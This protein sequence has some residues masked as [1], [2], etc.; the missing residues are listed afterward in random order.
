MTALINEAE[1]PL[2]ALM[3]NAGVASRAIVLGDHRLPIQLRNAQAEPCLNCSPL[4]HVITGG[5]EESRALGA[6]GAL[7]RPPLRLLGGLLKLGRLDQVA[8]INGQGYA[9]DLPPSLSEAEITA[10]TEALAAA[11]PDRA[12]VLRSL[13]RPEE[14]ERWR[15]AG[16]RSIVS[17]YIWTF[18]PAA[19]RALASPLLK[20]DGKLLA[21]SEYRLGGPES[22]TDEELPR[23]LTLY[24]QLY[25]KKYSR[26]NPRWTLDFFRRARD[27]AGPDL[28]VLRSAEG[29]IDGLVG[30]VERDGV[31]TAPIYGYDTG[32]PRELGLYRMLSRVAVDEARRRGCLLHQSAGAAR[33]K[34][35]RRA[36]GGLEWMAVYDRHLPRYRR[37]AWGLLAGLANGL[38]AP[39]LRRLEGGA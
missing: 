19:P 37:A 12:L 26:H 27:G 24:E 32:L 35:L 30:L 18:D 23:L 17:R 34:K 4:A 2:S 5:L 14:R 39:L 38:G 1:P 7:I 9:T 22:I 11:Y 13:W 3:T 15:R 29:R 31:L 28:C 8:L 10:L 21:G 16:Y 6:F 25:I 20:R 33:F 36:R